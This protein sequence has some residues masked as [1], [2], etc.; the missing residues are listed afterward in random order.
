V[1]T[2]PYPTFPTIPTPLEEIT[3]SLTRLVKRL[4]KV[5][6]EQIGSSVERTLETARAA[7]AQADRTLSSAG[8]LVG[9]DSPVNVELRR[10]LVELTDAARSVGLAAEQI[11]SQPDSLLFGRSE[12]Q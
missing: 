7:L 12:E 11:E 9:P 4:E 5:P 10:A 1:W 3:S 8:T 6:L 2:D